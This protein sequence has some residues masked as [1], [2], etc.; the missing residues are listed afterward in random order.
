V[1]VDL[2]AEGLRVLA[3]AVAATGWVP[4]SLVPEPDPLPEPA[5]VDE[6]EPVVDEPVVGEPVVD[7]PAVRE[8]ESVD[9][10]PA[11]VGSPARLVLVL[12]ALA[13]GEGLR[14]PAPDAWVTGTSRVGVEPEPRWPPW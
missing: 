8:P 12:E 11:A 2:S 5:V 1:R 9:P 7:E 10:E 3:L 4:G 6:P 14:V 13:V